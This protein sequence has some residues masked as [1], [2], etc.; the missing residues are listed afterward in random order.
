MDELPVKRVHGSVLDQLRALVSDNP[1]VVL[2]DDHSPAIVALT[3]A[4]WK[5]FLKLIGGIR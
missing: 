3:L 1:G 5:A 2:V 4:T